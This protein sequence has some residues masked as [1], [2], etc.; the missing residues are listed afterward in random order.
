MSLDEAASAALNNFKGVTPKGQLERVPHEGFSG[1]SL[2]KVATDDGPLCLKSW[3][4]SQPPPARMPRIHFL[5]NH[6]R[7]KGLGF[8]PKFY[9]TRTGEATA[10]HSGC[11]WELMTWLPGDADRS[12]RPAKKRLQAAFRALATFHQST[13]EWSELGGNQPEPLRPTPAIA[14]RLWRVQELSQGGLAA[15]IAAVRERSIPV[16]D[17]L[18]Q[19][20]ISTR[21]L[22]PEGLL[23]RLTI[24]GQQQY[25]VQPAIR[26]LWREHVLFTGDEVTGFIDFGALRFDMFHIDLARL[27]GSLAGDDPEQ[28]RT[29]IGAYDELRPL[30]GEDVALIDSLD[31]ASAWI[32]GWNWLEWLYV[33]KRMF[34]S[35][36]AVRD[37][38]THLLSRNITH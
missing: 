13:E 23:L 19:Q 28:R 30:R 26:D 18:A 38:L 31:G 25:I 1:C 27:I 5:I 36:A 17:D 8:L 37:R 34:P 16:L 12:T 4:S 35:L 9:A 15:I 7:D 3:P 11:A 32:A 22:P 29:A 33:E 14:E 6:T 10:M 21:R 24:A 20:W 2:W